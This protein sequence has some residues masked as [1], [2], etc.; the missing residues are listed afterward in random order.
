MCLFTHFAA[1]AL[2][3]GA[4][5]NV[6]LGAGAG[7]ASHAVL[8]AIPHYDH[9][10]WRLELL[11]G[12][13]SL[14]LLLLLPFGTLPAIIGG[15][16]GMV[17]DL[18][19][20]FQKLGKMRRDQFI[21][22]SHTGLV[23]HGRTLGPRTI[24]WQIAIFVVCYLLLGLLVPGTAQ[25][26]ATFQEGTPS[27]KEVSG[28]PVC[29]MERPLVT[30]LGSTANT[31]LIRID[32]PVS[33]E[34]ADW[35][36]V[37]P[38]RVKW[39][40]SVGILEENEALGSDMPSIPYVPVNLAVPTT[41]N[42]TTRLVDATW[43]KQPS[44]QSELSG[45]LQFSS[46]AVF[47]SVPMAGT[48]V[49]VVIDGGIPASLV[50]EVSHPVG[51]PMADQLQKGQIASGPGKNSKAS[52]PV[53]AGV[54]N[55]ALFDQLSRGGYAVADETAALSRNNQSAKAQISDYFGLTSRWI[56]LELDE[57]GLFS[58]SGQDM[59]E[60]GVGTSG[61]DPAKIR[62][63]RGGGLPLTTEPTYADTL[64]M[65]RA[66]LTEVAI[67]VIGGQDGEWN[68][69]DEIHFFAFGS[70][71]YLDR[72]DD[73]ALPLDHFDHPYSAHG[74]YWLTWESL[75]VASP[76]PGTPLRVPTVDAGA[77]NGDVTS[78]HRIRQHYEQQ[79][80]DFA[81]LVYDGFLWET[82]LTG[83]L[84]SSF[85]INSPE[86][87]TGVRVVAEV[88][89][90]PANGISLTYSFEIA[91]WVNGNTSQTTNVQLTRPD[92][93]DSLK[94]RVVIESDAI[95]DGNNVLN[96]RNNNPP[97]YDYFGNPVTKQPWALDSFDVFYWTR[98]ALDQGDGQLVFSHWGEQ[99]SAPG[100][101]VDLKLEV[102][103]SLTPQL[104]D[105]TDHKAPVIL[106]GQNDGGIPN[107]ITYGVVRDPDSRRHFVAG[108]PS[109][110]LSV[111]RGQRVTP[112]S[113]RGVDPDL[114]YIV[115]YNSAFSGPAHRLAEFYGTTLPGVQSPEARAFSIQDI[116][117]SYSGGQK[118][119]YAIRNFLRDMYTNG[120]MRL[121]YV[122]IVGN[123]SRDYRNFLNREPLVDLYDLVPTVVR[124]NF[125]AHPLASLLYMPHATDDALVSFDRVDVGLLDYPDVAC[126]RLPA[127]NLTEAEGMV[128]RCIAYVADPDPGLW[129]NNVLMVA[130]DNYVIPKYGAV[131]VSGEDIHTVEADLLLQEYF[132]PSLDAR[133]IFGVEYPFPPGSSVKPQC[134]ND[135]KAA[136]SAGTTIFHYIGHGAENNL[137]DEQ[138]FQSSDLP[139]LTNE[140]KRSIFIAFSCDVGI[141]DSPSRRSMAES[142]LTQENGGAIGAICASQV[143][144]IYYNN[145]LSEFFYSNLFPDRHVDNDIPVAW[146]LL[147]AKASITGSR[148]IRNSQRFNLLGDPGMA[149]VH[150]EDDL[151]LA[152]TSVD[153]LRAGARQEAVLEATG[154]SVLLGAGDQYGIW[155]Q[156]AAYD[157]HFPN[158]QFGG[159][160][161][162][163]KYGSAIFKGNGTMGSGDLAVPF[164]VP[165][166]LRYGDEARIRLMITTVDGVHTAVDQLPSVRASL[167]ANNDIIGPDITLAF[168]DNRYKVR[169][170]TE[171]AA[172]LYDTSSIAILGTSPGNSLMLEFDDTGFMTDVTSY[173]IFDA[174]SYQQGRIGFPLPADLDYGL[175]KAALHASDAL[176]NVG[177][178]TLSF[179]LVP[180]GIS[181]IGDMTLFPNPTPGYCRLIFE[182]SDPMDVRW[183]IYTLSGRRLK[184]V[185]EN[186]VS[187][188]PQILH[189]DGLDAQGDEIANGTY[190]YVVR[191]TWS[192]G[193][194][195]TK[196]GKLVI[197][198]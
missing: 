84:P 61:V 88:R 67:D 137:A 168:E 130:D 156:E 41:S 136:L 65:D 3:G 132:P 18:E 45:V 80:V 58:L 150:P 50:I 173:F 146:A 23:P 163:V 89:A 109:D 99:V 95:V 69:D 76:L 127:S 104:W 30:L 72:L 198:R 110:F 49:P 56:R 126:G 87:G 135:I 53:P 182:L 106:N 32:F 175:H 165:V 12:I 160:N 128:D 43:W 27:Y 96:L 83:S 161:S 74:I 33:M 194:D 155:V 143:S 121:K 64:Q 37:D 31:S 142:F 1:G 98:L 34:P 192:G 55:D 191:G 28:D 21:Y 184:T 116:F 14:I 15:M 134:R 97:F 159:T 79:Y 107:V 144:F 193:R 71:H 24:V 60:M 176:G 25:A 164:Q 115:I 197:M 44:G 187:A 54:L 151:A 36:S 162:F 129:A 51:R 17:P 179:E 38:A 122:A 114:D 63:Y 154:K 8:D 120:G 166:Q 152:A 26:Q 70:S 177:S 57:T 195:V 178:D 81:G 131:P 91:G 196:T 100:T 188:G 172:T 149:F 22:P 16:F 19:N 153:T 42:V 167:G 7:F 46:P 82:H 93:D 92:Q 189:W 13:F 138:I 47:R 9:P 171:L 52:D 68:L 140:N 169:V 102:A 148:S 90:H 123:P 141:Y 59:L 2:A 11:G 85:A 170:G 147:M 10:D 20:L 139:N 124:T 158:N 77:L 108:D 86:E 174:D 186:F 111:N 62:L 119:P 6:W 4:T 133:Q 145:S 105:V 185:R 117:D 35:E 94:V 48:H 5:G 73:A 118:D 75:A 66:S 29:T 125:P 113:L 181:G 78:T 103:G 40:L 180:A 39:G 112:E 157:Y 183:E 101:A 190:L